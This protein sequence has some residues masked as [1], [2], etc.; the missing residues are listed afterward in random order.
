[1]AEAAFEKSVDDEVD[2]GRRDH[3]HGISDQVIDLWCEPCLEETKVKVDAVGYCPECNIHL[4]LSC[5][6]SH[7]KWPMLQNHRLLRGSR[8]P[9]SHADKPIRYPDCAS[10]A[11]NYTDHYCSNHEQMV[12]NNCLKKD[13]LGC[14]ALPISDVCKSINT[15]DVKQFKIVVNGIQNNVKTTQAAL[16]KNISDTESQKKVM[17]KTAESERD[18]LISKVN[19]MFKKTVSN[20]NSTCHK[21]TS[22]ISEHIEIL[23]DENHQLD[24]V[25]DTFDKKTITDIDANGF[26]QIQNI[27][28]STK[29]CKQEIEDAIRQ[30]HVSE[31]SLDLNEDVAQ[32]Y[33]KHQLG[34]PKEIT[35]PLDTLKDVPNIAF[36]QPRKKTA[37]S[38]VDI[39]KICATKT[40]SFNVKRQLGTPK[41]I[42]KP[43]DTMKNVPNIIFPQPKKKKSK[44]SKICAW[45]TSSIHVKTT[46]DKEL[47]LINGMAITDNGT[48][49]IADETNKKVKIFYEDNT[50]LTTFEMSEPI[51]A[52]AV[53]NASEAVVSTAD[54]KLHFLDIS[55]LPTVSIR[56][57]V[58]LEYDVMCLAPCGDNIV[59]ASWETI[60][61]SLK[62]I[63]RNGKEIWSISTGPDNQQL[64][65]WPYAV[66]ITT[67]KGVN[68]AVVTDWKKKTLT[69]IDVD[70]VAVLKI[71]YFKD[72]DLRGVAVDDNGN[73]FVSSRATREILVVSKDLTKSRVILEGQFGHPFPRVLLYRR[74]TG[75]LYVSYIKYGEIDRLKL[76]VAD[77]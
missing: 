62:M 15:E 19:D 6:E 9:K 77:E 51:N 35:K 54:R 18:K 72:K 11:G 36:P 41:E 44:I 56:E 33:E 42:T 17:V 5:H 10:H 61:A 13:H 50:L 70:N 12:C 67:F 24:E 45:K 32:L 55:K 46:R 38:V 68:A 16:Q 57:S 75:E 43:L 37:R 22:E 34:R 2:D 23:S 69:V 63:D 74:S 30:L 29:E 47:C 71:K 20:I 26:I 8:M 59:V 7:K 14:E 58:S 48:L 66:Q 65:E 39:S 49:L 1:M 21:T 73:F 27:V 25:I 76:S 53:I 3:E 4:C 64:F 40:L 60:P 52:I 31:L 28:A